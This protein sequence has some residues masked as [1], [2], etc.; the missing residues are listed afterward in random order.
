MIHLRIM[1]DSKEER[2][3]AIR[4]TKYLMKMMERRGYNVQT[5]LK[6]YKNKKNQGGRIYLNIVR[7]Q[8]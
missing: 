7:K 1:Y 8:S 3:E 2:V 6:I 5:N 4:L